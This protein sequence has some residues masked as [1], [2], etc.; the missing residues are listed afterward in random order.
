MKKLLL[1]IP[2][3][4]YQW[5]DVPTNY[6]T[7]IGDYEDINHVN[8]IG[9]LIGYLQRHE[10]RFA[11]IEMEYQM[12]ETVCRELVRDRLRF[13]KEN[14]EIYHTAQKLSHFLA[15]FKEGIGYKFNDY[16][17]IPHVLSN[18]KKIQFGTFTIL[19]NTEEEALRHIAKIFTSHTDFP[20]TTVDED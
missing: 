2:V 4:E 7:C 5:V 10:D 13:V 18:G 16:K 20:F 8:Q 11:I 12:R 17:F 9:D 3:P 15:G 19:F 1:E 6:R 14:H